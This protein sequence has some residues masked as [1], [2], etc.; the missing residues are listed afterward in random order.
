[1]NLKS[2]RRAAIKPIRY[3]LRQRRDPI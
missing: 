3:T 1:M 2:L